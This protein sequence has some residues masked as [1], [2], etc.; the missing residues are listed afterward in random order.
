MVVNDHEWNEL[1]ET[2]MKKDFYGDIK[3]LHEVIVAEIVTLMAVY[4][5]DEVDLLGSSADHAYVCGYPGDGADVMEMEV[6]RVHWENGQLMLD[7]ILDTDTD[8]LAEQN[9]NGDIGDAYQCWR[10]NDFTHFKPCAGIEMV[11]DSVYQVLEQK[12]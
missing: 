7:V 8:E 4:G 10:A 6:S 11:Y 9:E 2:T 12:K 3:H 5:V 1:N